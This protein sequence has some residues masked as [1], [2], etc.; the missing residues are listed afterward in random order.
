M[1]RVEV[2]RR[3]LQLLE[4]EIERK[5]VAHQQRLAKAIATAVAPFAEQLDQLQVAVEA[6]AAREQIR[7]ERSAYLARCNL[8]PYRNGQTRPS[9]EILQ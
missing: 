5:Q 8:A 1:T 2:M 3:V 9:E 4:V 7:M 6:L